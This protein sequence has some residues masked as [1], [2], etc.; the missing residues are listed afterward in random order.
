[1]K[2]AIKLDERNNDAY[3]K[4]KNAQ[5][6]KNNYIQTAQ[7]NILTQ[8]D[9]YFVS[10]RRPSE[11]LQLFKYIYDQ[12]NKRFGKYGYVDTFMTIVIPPIYDFDYNT[13]YKG[14]ENFSLGKALVCLKLSN[15]DTIYMKINK[16]NKVVEVFRK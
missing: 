3:T 9:K 13:M 4:L 5:K 12:D 16:S 2:K 7:A 15:N 10:L 1:Y 6:Y 8:K 14:S 11:G